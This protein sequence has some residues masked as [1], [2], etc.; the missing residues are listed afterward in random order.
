M[1][2]GRGVVRKSAI[3]DSRVVNGISI[4]WMVGHLGDRH[5]RNAEVRLLLLSFCFICT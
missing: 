1:D 2:L 3:E 5:H 4:K